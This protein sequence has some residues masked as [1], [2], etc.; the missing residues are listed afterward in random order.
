M[1]GLL[2]FLS[3]PEAQ[4]GIGLLAAGG[5]RTDPNQTGLGTRLADAMGYVQKGQD[6]KNA[7]KR[8]QMQ[9]QMY[10]MQMDEAR[11]K[12]AKE[13]Q[14]T[15]MAARFQGSP[16]MAPLQGDP[17]SGIAPSAGQPATGF[18]YSGYA[19]ALAGVDPM[20]AL[21]LQQSLQKD[22]TPIK[23][24]AG[25]QMFSGKASG[26]KPLLSVPGKEAE[27][28]S[29]VREYEYAKKQGYGGSYVDFQLAQKRAGASSVSVSMTDGQKG[30]ENEMKLG[31]AFKQE[32]IYKAHAEVQSAFSQV[33]AALN[34]GTPVGDLAGATKIM[35]IL[36]PGSVVRESELGM[37]MAAG[38][39]MDRLQNYV[40]QSMDG[41]KLTPQ[42]RTDFTNLSTELTAASAQA[43]NSK[44]K[45]YEVQGSEYGLNAPRALGKAVDVPSIMKPDSKTSGLSVTAPNGKTYTFKSESE[46]KSFKMAAGLK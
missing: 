43:Y 21:S 30:F 6:R 41:T 24:G 44:R 4:M 5:P 45:E 35:K 3:S 11:Q 13:R 39:R 37:A 18:D 26:Y 14:M 33:T 32:P 1:A 8:A 22:D 28:P 27:L 16:G 20:K 34:A 36:D 25:E 15:D 29:A 40:K 12:M 10:Q 9:D 42:Q 17:A 38:G 46:M 19:Q 7:E 2:D 31:G 23:L